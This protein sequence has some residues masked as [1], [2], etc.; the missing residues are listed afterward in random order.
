MTFEQKNLKGIAAIN[1]GSVSVN[2]AYETYKCRGAG[3]CPWLG[4]VLLQAS[5]DSDSITRTY[6][7]LIELFANIGGF[8]SMFIAV[9][10]TMNGL[11]V[12]FVK[13]YYQVQETFG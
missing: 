10:S 8:I 9:Y 12:D 13:E 2:R 1:F 5:K 6:P 7:K 4:G 3:D 11:L